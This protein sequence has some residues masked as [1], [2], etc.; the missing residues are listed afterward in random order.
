MI[1]VLIHWKIRPEQEMVD[2]FLKFWRETAI[3]DDRRGLLEN[4]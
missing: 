2:E 4:S 3:I 1:V